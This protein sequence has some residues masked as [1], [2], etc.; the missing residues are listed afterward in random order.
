MMLMP[1]ENA[2]APEKTSIVVTVGG[3]KQLAGFLTRKDS[4]IM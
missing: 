1:P 4:T 3:L 2:I